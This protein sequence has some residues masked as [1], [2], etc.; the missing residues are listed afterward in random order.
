MAG[1]GALGMVETQGMVGAIEAADAMVK[2]GNV[3]VEGYRT[4]GDGVVSVRVRGDVGAVE[5]AVAAGAAA[6][7]AIGE[8]CASHVI[9]R[10][11][12]ETERILGQESAPID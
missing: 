10:P 7:A 8:L 5:A 12:A 9:A 3:V 1:G 4:L 6:A 11:H 2:S